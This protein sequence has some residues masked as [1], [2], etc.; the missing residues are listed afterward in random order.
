MW[1]G[2]GT[3]PPEG[4]KFCRSDL[5]HFRCCFLWRA[6]WGLPA[7]EETAA[8]QGTKIKETILGTCQPVV[9]VKANVRGLALIC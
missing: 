5:S 4:L 9:Q 2:Q 6:S 8:L 1:G 3:V 7:L